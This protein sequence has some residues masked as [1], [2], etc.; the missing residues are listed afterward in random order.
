MRDINANMSGSIMD[1]LNTPFPWEDAST[2]N[3]WRSMHALEMK[4]KAQETE[5]KGTPYFLMGDALMPGTGHDKLIIQ[6]ITYTII[7]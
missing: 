2:W 1:W 6:P 7:C 5:D 3:E 4:Q